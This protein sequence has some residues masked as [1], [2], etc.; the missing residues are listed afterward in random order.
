[1]TSERFIELISSAQGFSLLFIIA[2]LL[3]LLVFKKDAT[4]SKAR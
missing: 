1:M 3:M 2:V 4:R